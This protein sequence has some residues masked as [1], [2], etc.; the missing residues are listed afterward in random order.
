MDPCIKMAEIISPIRIEI[1]R[2]LRDEMHPEELGR[3][4]N[5]TRQAVDKHLSILY[6]LGFV[7]KRIKV[8]TR[9]MI[10]Y[11]I[12]SE[13]DDFLQR[14]ED[15]TQEHILS[16]RKRYKDEL[17]NLDKM[18]VEGEI[19]ERDYRERR[20]VLERRFQWVMEK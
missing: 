14:F 18:L 7:D 11:R 13:G 4:F 1:L 8:G 17:F 5:I 9:P 6:K 15:L 19:T 12:T 20:R 10:F 3:K 2:M 16:L